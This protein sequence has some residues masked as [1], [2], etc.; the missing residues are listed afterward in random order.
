MAKL[1][2]DADPTGMTAIVRALSIGANRQE[3]VRRLQMI[4]FMR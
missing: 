4:R 2:G 3:T 1:K